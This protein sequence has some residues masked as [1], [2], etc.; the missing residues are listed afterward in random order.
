MYI[1]HIFQARPLPSLFGGCAGGKKRKRSAVCQPKAGKI[2]TKDVVCLLPRK[3][4]SII[5]IP[6]GKNRV[7]LAEMG[8]IGKVCINS[9]WK[10]E[11]VANE[12][13]SVFAS[14]FNLQ[15]GEVLPFD[16]LG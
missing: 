11:E 4:G 3:K 15:P 2:Y 7:R 10:A 5:P 16:Y 1:A 8:L 9:T 14:V 6:R 12:I 13:T